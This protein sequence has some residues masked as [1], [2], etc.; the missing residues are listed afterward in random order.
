MSVVLVLRP[1]PGASRTAHAV[2]ALGLAARVHPLF[3]PHPVAWV[4]PDPAYFDALLVTSAHTAR[5]AGVDIARYRALPAYAVG[6]AT[7]QALRD[8]GFPNVTAGVGDGSAIASRIARDGHVR[9]LHP[10]GTT[11]ASINAGSLHIVLVAVYTMQPA[12]PGDA[13]L[14]DATPGAVCLVHS[15]RAGERLAHLV[16]PALRAALHLVAISPAARDASGDG[17]ASTQA[18]DRPRDE[19]MLALAARLCKDGGGQSGKGRDD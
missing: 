11:T 17:W 19:E 12:D 2:E 14:R 8:L 13:L 10:G 7:A 1:E 15:P 18:P 3:A 4:A 5:L 6:D 16:P 9:V